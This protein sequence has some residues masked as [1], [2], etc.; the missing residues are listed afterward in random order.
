M[1]EIKFRAWDGHSM[2]G[3]G[4]NDWFSVRNDGFISSNN[5]DGFES[6]L[7]Q[8]IGL[9]DKNGE[10]IYEGDIVHNY[11]VMDSWI[12]EVIF[13]PEFGYVCKD[14]LDPVYECASEVEV[15]GNI[16][17]HPELVEAS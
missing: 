16:Y 8:Y 2:R 5:H 3:T 11:D 6:I 14:S 17:E 4:K 9:K 15:I 13:M 12:D 7:M 10:E 1:R